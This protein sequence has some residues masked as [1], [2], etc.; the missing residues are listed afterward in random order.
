M[1][2]DFGRWMD[3]EITKELVGI[4]I[5]IKQY[6]APVTTYSIGT[7][8]TLKSV[9]YWKDGS[10]SSTISGEEFLKNLEDQKEL[11]KVLKEFGQTANE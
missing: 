8:G 9:S 2:G 11:E 6:G 1:G 4:N 5:T 7:D 3:R 10:I